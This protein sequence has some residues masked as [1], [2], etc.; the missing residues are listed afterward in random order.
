MK[1]VQELLDIL[2]FIIY[3]KQFKFKIYSSW[4]ISIIGQFWEK[5]M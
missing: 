5:N 2:F 3:L 4:K 1:E